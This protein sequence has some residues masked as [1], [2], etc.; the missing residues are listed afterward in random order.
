MSWEALAKKQI[1]APFV[2]NIRHEMDLSNFSEEFTKQAPL[3]SPSIVPPSE[4]EKLF[5]VKNKINILLNIIR[6]LTFQ[7]PKLYLSLLGFFG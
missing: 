2:P 6:L 4:G 1:P 5:K 7:P 3:E